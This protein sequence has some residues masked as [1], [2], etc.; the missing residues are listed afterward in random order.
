MPFF[1]NLFKPL[2]FHL[3][4]FHPPRQLLHD[5]TPSSN[6]IRR[7][8]RNC[9]NRKEK[10]FQSR[11]LVPALCLF[12]LA[13]VL[14]CAAP[15]FAAQVTLAWDPNAS[16][17]NGYRLFQRMAGGS[18]DY[19]SPVWS[20]SGTTC[21]VNNLAAGT[22]YYFVVRAYAGADESGDS[23]EVSYRPAAAPATTYTITASAG[24]N[25]TIAP[26]GSSNVVSGGSR[27]Y[28]I[29]A[30]AGYQIAGV[31]VDGVS[32]GT[33]SSYSFSNVTANH[34]IAATFKSTGQPVDPGNDPPVADAGANQTVAAG[35]VVTL[36]GTGSYD[37]EGGLLA[38][39]WTQTSGATVRLSGAGTAQPGFTA[40]QVTAGH[41]LWLVFELTV[42][43]NGALTGQ[44]TCI[45]RVDAIATADTDGDGVSD[46][47]DAFPGD[48]SESLDTDL[49]GIGNNS[50]P[51]DDNDGMPDA[52]ELQ[53]GLNPVHDDSGQDLDN[54]GITNLAEYLSGS[55]PTHAPRN[56]APLA[57]EMLAPANG[58]IAVSTTPV[59]KASAFADPDAGDSHGK[60]EWRITRETTQ[61]TVFHAVR[62]R[63][64]LTRLRV[65]RLV[66]DGSATYTCQ[67]RYYDDHGLMSQWSSPV[68]FT[69]H[70]PENAWCD[71][72]ISK[73]PTTVP[74]TDLNGDQVLDADEPQVIRTIQSLDGQ[75]I[76]GIGVEE[77]DSEIDAAAIIDPGAEETDA[78]SY[79]LSAYRL[80][81]YRIL[82]DE[83]GAESLVTLYFSG[84]TTPQTGWICYDASGEW[85]DD[86]SEIYPQAGTSMVIRMVED[87]GAEDADGVVNGVIIDVLGIDGSP[88]PDGVDHSLDNLNEADNPGAAG[89]SSCFI[90][91]L[92]R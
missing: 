91:S 50:D 67:V 73:D 82:V 51:D 48:P 3:T 43:D 27:I 53:Y 86:I 15:L 20:G 42:M 62:S 40:P 26:S 35:S 18:Y 85:N 37:P 49:D 24:P 45:V 70:C 75:T 16:P 57:P 88:V 92:L 87:G 13:T 4:S 28:T 5:D 79:D 32:V 47:Q 76:I 19:A 17:P 74:D 65:P 89:G 33:V 38:Y 55:D 61:E 2:F 72:S 36:H 69:T 25:G 52:W 11:R 1:N 34:T 60:T 39:R 83:P 6:P 64:W 77:T 68:T 30:N 54:D 66:L 21:T 80:F 8:K 10:A 7:Q 9:H 23:N 90:G 22:L 44:D 46:D 31:L 59:L 63:L 14:T 71:D 56:Q 81:T 84:D 29:S 12:V 78:D 41:S 58:E